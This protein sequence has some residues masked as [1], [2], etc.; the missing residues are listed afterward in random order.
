MSF[1]TISFLA[2]VLPYG[3]ECFYFRKRFGFFA[4]IFWIFVIQVAILFGGSW[5]IEHRIGSSL[6][7]WLNAIGTALGAI[8]FCRSE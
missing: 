8:V 5:L 6:P 3:V 4:L 2:V 7:A 1:L